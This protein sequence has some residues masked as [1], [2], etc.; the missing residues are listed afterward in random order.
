MTSIPTQMIPGALSIGVETLKALTPERIHLRPVNQAQQYTPGGVNRINFRIPSYSNSF[1]DTS[2]CFLTY[3]LGYTTSTTVNTTNYCAPVNGANFVNRLVVKS[4]AGLVIDDIGNYNVLDAMNNAILP[5]GHALNAMEGRVASSMETGVHEEL[6][7][8]NK[9]FV[10]EGI[11][12][13][14]CFQGGLFSKSTQ[15]WLPVG[16]MDGGSGFALDLD[17]YLADTA[18]VIKER[19]VVVNPQYFVKDVVLHLETAELTKASAKSSTK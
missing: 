6:Y 18:G 16:M 14:H 12:Y 4:S 9:N 7:A 11:E 15:K 19:G 2:K 17:L 3:K 5:V 1:L 8:T 13:R 10:G